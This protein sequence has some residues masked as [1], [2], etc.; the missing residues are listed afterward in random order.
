MKLDL[1]S[2]TSQLSPSSISLTIELS[3]YLSSPKGF[4]KL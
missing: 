3:R 1:S 4:S 2:S